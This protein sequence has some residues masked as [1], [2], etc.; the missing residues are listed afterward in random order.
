M[1]YKIITCILFAILLQTKAVYVSAQILNSTDNK[2]LGTKR[3]ASY[4]LEEI[5][6]R[7]KK[8]ALENCTGVPC[9]DFICGISTI[10]DIDGNVYNTVAIGNQCWSKENLKVTRYNDGT[11]IPDETTSTLA[12][13]VALNTG[14]RTEYVGTILTASGHSPVNDY[15]KTY[16]Y[17]YNWYAAAGIVSSN[18][19]LL[20][21]IC[22]TGWHVPSDSEWSILLKELD[23]NAVIS[24]SQWESFTASGKMKDN[25][26]W[27]GR[28]ALGGAFPPDPLATNSSGFTALPA[29][30]RSGTGSGS[31][32]SGVL[33]GF[34][35]IGDVAEFWSIT[36]FSGVP[37]AYSR[38]L[39][40]SNSV[41]RVYWPRAQGNSVRCI[42]TQ[43]G[44]GPGPN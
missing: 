23:I 2:E 27:S 28:P 17:L 5:K 37:A 9:N 36:P 30:I 18:G 43:A 35:S 4:N 32:V 14:A 11:S 25:K 34:Y 15:V 40:A 31:G 3:N 33:G 22:P 44:P 12:N 10:S 38:I 29:G 1:K 39:D 24:S 21:N 26:D 6:V 20:K 42:K 19:P 7:W 16:G 8:A 41:S 13:W